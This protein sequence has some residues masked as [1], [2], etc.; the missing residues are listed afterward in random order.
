MVAVSLQPGPEGERGGEG[1]GQ[2]GLYRPKQ[3]RLGGGR[4]DGM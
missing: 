4:E 2:E 1:A 3:L